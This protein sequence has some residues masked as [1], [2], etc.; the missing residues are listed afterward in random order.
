MT[1]AATGAAPSEPMSFDAAVAS[2]ASAGEPPPEEQAAAPVGDEQ[3]TED[4][5]AES[6]AEDAG[7]PTEAT[8]EGEQEQTQ[9]EPAGPALDPPAL[10]D[11]AGKAAFAALPREHQETILAQVGKQASNASKAI[12]QAAEARKAA[13]GQASKVTQLADALNGFLPKA[14]ETFK[15]R[16]EG[17]DWVSVAQQ[18]DP[19]QYQAVRA[20]YEAEA[21]ELE[22]VRAATQQA[23]ALAYEEHVKKVNTDLPTAAPDLVDPKEGNA[24]LQKV[25][26]FLQGQGYQPDRLKHVTAQDLSLAY[27]AMRWREAQAGAKTALKPTPKPAAPAVR[28]TAVQGGNSQQRATAA[29]NRFAQTRSV[30]DAVALLLAKG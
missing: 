28:P 13:E 10:W 6:Q 7:E 1:D 3:Q 19:Q 21:Q 12:E 14:M 2:L 15:G 11:D 27:D 5:P 18:L 8:A 26:S 23:D 17:V 9:D 16:W 4:T 20:Q 25:F 22:R 29:K 30:D 24:R